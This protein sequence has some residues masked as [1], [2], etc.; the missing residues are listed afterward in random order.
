MYILCNF[1]SFTFQLREIFEY[2]L[3]T[4]VHFINILSYLL[5][6]DF[7]FSLVFLVILCACH[8]FYKCLFLIFLFSFS[9][10]LE[11]LVLPLVFFFHLVANATFQVFETFF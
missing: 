8:F 1:I 2:C 9:L 11:M 6:L 5:F 3:Y 4:T 10:V 7:R